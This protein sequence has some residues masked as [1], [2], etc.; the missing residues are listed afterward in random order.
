EAQAREALDRDNAGVTGRYRER[1]YVGIEQNSQTVAEVIAAAAAAEAQAPRPTPRSAP[2]VVLAAGRRGELMG[3]LALSR[4]GAGAAV[5]REELTAGLAPAIAEPVPPV[6]ART[7]R[8]EKHVGGRKL[9]EGG[10]GAVYL[11]LAK[12]DVARER[13]LA[14]KV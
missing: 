12:D 7:G 11:A 2:A 3:D 13:P 10:M 1:G 5:A 6:L 4:E 8:Q 9:G 14:L